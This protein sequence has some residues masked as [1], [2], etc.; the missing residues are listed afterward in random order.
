MKVQRKRRPCRSERVHKH[1]GNA[2]I[3]KLHPIA[4]KGTEVY[5]ARRWRVLAMTVLASILLLLPA[6][7][8][9][10]SYSTGEVVQLGATRPAGNQELYFWYLVRVDGKVYEITR[11]KGG[12]FDVQIHQSVQCRIDGKH[13]LVVLGDGRA[14]RFEIVPSK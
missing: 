3:R 7:I 4:R 10:Q 13:M 12:K 8:W 6:R 5:V 9:A 14:T 11:H 2:I 1:P